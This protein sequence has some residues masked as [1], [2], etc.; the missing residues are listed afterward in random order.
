M[1]IL[2]KVNWTDKADSSAPH[3]RIRHIGGFSSHMN[4]QHSQ[5]QA[6]EA[7]ERGHFTYYLEKDQRALT[8]GVAVTSDGRKYLTLNAPDPHW[9]MNLP[10]SPQPKASQK[11]GSQSNT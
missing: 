10:D 5:A 3:E 4:W 7:I 6:I 9:L 8:L 2:L 1:A 11:P